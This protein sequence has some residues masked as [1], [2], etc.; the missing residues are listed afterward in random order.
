MKEWK[1]YSPKSLEQKMEYTE[2][3][4]LP[5]RITESDGK[6]DDLAFRNKKAKATNLFM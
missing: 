5:I 1:F 4:K 6:N 2:W 3:T